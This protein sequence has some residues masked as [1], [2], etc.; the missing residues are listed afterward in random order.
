MDGSPVEPKG[1]IEVEAPKKAVD[2]RVGVV[3]VKKSP[4]RLGGRVLWKLNSGQ[5]SVLGLSK[6]Y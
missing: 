2:M 3:Y 4:E 5:I 6:R 1:C